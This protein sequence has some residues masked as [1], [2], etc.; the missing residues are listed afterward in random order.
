MKPYLYNGTLT[1]NNQQIWFHFYNTYQ[2]KE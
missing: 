2:Q 1:F